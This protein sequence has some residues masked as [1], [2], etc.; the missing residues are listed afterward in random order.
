MTNAA[1]GR[2]DISVPACDYRR[3]L[4]IISSKWTVLVIYALQDG[5]VRYAEIRKRIDGI[6]QKMLTQTLR[7]L[8]RDGLVKRDVYPSV[9]PTVEYELTPLGE[10]LIPY[11]RQLQQWTKAY[12]PLVEKARKD[13]D[14]DNS[15]G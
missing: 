4:E 8:E 13:Y 10:T 11:L 12:Y 1:A 3:M 5:S 9:P 7:Q 15:P 2:V 6:S 14:R